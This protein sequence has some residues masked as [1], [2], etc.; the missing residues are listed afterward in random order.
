[1]SRTTPAAQQER[2][3][4]LIDGIEEAGERHSRAGPENDETHAPPRDI[5]IIAAPHNSPHVTAEWNNFS[6]RRRKIERK[7]YRAR[8]MGNTKNLPRVRNI[9]PGQ[10]KILPKMHTDAGNCD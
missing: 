9:R 7:I 3:G 4:L 10:I 1:M 2:R 5:I 8:Q 6:P